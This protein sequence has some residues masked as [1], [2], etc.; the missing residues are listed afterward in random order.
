MP[1]NARSPAA[2]D[3]RPRRA[4]AQPR[5]LKTDLTIRFTTKLLKPAGAGKAVIWTFLTLPKDASDKLP[6]RGQVSVEGAL[7]GTPFEATLEPDGKGGHWLKVG[8]ELGESAGAVV[9]DVVRLE[10]APMAQEPEPKIPADL[11]GALADSTPAARDTRSDITSAARRDF[12]HWV[13]SPKRPETRAKRIAT[14]CDMLAKGKRR[15]CCFDRSGRDSK[16]L[17]R[18]V[19]DHA[20]GGTQG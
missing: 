5:G 20:L 6:S 3:R 17:S 9:G 15:P 2:A 8:E 12:V 10:V 4:S 19:A 13:T 1:R 18:P 11:R 14:A 16:R 7:N